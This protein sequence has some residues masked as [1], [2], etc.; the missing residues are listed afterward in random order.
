MTV[1]EDLFEATVRVENMW[2]FPQETPPQSMRDVLEENY[3]ELP[4]G[5]AHLVRTPCF[6]FIDDLMGEAFFDRAFGYLAEVA[7]PVHRKVAEN[8]SSFSW[9]HYYTGLIFAET[10]EELMAKAIA[11]AK[12]N[13]EK[14]MAK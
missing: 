13:H 1:H 10:V 8:T 2:P 11:W 14:D 3:D 9:G 4:E 7:C 5:I 12:E 6:D